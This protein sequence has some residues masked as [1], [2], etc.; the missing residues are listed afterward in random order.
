MPTSPAFA[1][2]SHAL[3]DVDRAP[4]AAGEERAHHRGVLLGEQVRGDLPRLVCPGAP[5]ILELVRADAAA[6]RGECLVERARGRLGAAMVQEPLEDCDDIARRRFSA[7]REHS[8]DRE[9]DII[10]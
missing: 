2:H 8:L 4:R 9:D 5:S 10:D 7:V 1:A 3:A 6:D